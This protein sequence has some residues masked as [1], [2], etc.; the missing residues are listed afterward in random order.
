VDDGGGIKT[1]SDPDIVKVSNA[2]LLI[3]EDFDGK[4]NDRKEQIEFSKLMVGDRQL[5]KD[6][7]YR[8]LC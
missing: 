2:P 7:L 1:S 4:W 5:V 3:V 6:L 8:L